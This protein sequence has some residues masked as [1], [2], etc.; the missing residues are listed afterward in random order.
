[1]VLLE[2]IF[3]LMHFLPLIVIIVKLLMEE[4]EVLE[5]GSLAPIVFPFYPLTVDVQQSE[6]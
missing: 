2:A 3:T 5:D 1:M 4:K 6:I